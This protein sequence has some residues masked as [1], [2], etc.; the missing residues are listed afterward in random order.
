MVWEKRPIYIFLPRPP[1]RNKPRPSFSHDT[2]HIQIQT[3]TPVLSTPSFFQPSLTLSLSR[4]SPPQPSPLLPLLN[5]CSL[6]RASLF[7]SSKREFIRRPQ[8]PYSPTKPSTYYAAVPSFRSLNDEIRRR[9]LVTIART[10]SCS[11]RTRTCS[12]RSALPQ[13]PSQWS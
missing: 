2:L 4:L 1:P 5:S 12:C 11:Q 7:F 10:W 3:H 8:F 13:P 6:T 9:F